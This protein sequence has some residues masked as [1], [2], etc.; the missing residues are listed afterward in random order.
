MLHV[1]PHGVQLVAGGRGEALSR[2]ATDIGRTLD[3]EQLLGDDPHVSRT[4]RDPDHFLAGEVFLGEP[5]SR[6]VIRQRS[7]S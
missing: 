7:R 3:P 2:L 6:P 1:E 4:V 5:A